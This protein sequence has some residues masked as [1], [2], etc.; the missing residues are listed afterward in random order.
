VAFEIENAPSRVVEKYLELL[1]Y[2]VDIIETTSEV[3]A[4][5]DLYVARNILT[6]KYYD[7]ATH[8]A[9][10]TVHRIDVLVSWNFRHIV[11]FDKMRLFN[12]VN[13]EQGY[14]VISIHSPREV[15]I[16]GRI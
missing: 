12:T 8:I 4:L 2:Q 5:A 6:E 3:T 11:H 1:T 10:A 7:D 16:Y 9:L 13:I 14:Q 15:S